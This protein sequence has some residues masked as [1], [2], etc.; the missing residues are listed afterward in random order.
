MSLQRRPYILYTGR[1]LLIR[2]SVPF[3]SLPLEAAAGCHPIQHLD[4]ALFDALVRLLQLVF[5][6]VLVDLAEKLVVEAVESFLDLWGV[7]QYMSLQHEVRGRTCSRYALASFGLF[8]LV[9]RNSNISTR[10]SNCL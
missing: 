4:V 8:R 6:L 2:P 7:D 10:R 1:D 5:A 9:S 3:S